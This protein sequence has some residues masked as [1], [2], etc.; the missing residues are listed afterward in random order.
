MS[1]TPSL[2]CL[3]G[4]Q[5]SRG[6]AVAA[7]VVFAFLM[8]QD[9]LRAQNLLSNPDFDAPDGL[10]GWILHTGTWQLG[11]DSG[12]CT[13]SGTI[14]G[15]SAIS[16]SSHYFYVV[17][18]QCIAVDPSATPELYLAAMYRTTANVF[19]RLYLQFFSD[20]ACATPIGWS[21]SVFGSTS[22][23]WNRIG[24]FLPLNPN[25]GSVSFHADNNP[26]TVGEPQFTV[27]WDRFYLGVEPQL[28]LEDFEFEGGSACRWS[29]VVG[30]I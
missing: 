14:D 23:N 17:P 6:F 7:I 29:S 19:A 25:A 8:S 18:D 20:G 24:D 10:S 13:T 26:E 16:G 15:T 27:Q 28:L 11:A 4:L 12:S 30:G 5:R 9:S 2:P 22:A 3:T 1:E 21:S